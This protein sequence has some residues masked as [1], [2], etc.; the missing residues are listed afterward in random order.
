MPPFPN[1]PTDAQ[2]TLDAII[3]LLVAAV[4]AW[5]NWHKSRRPAPDYERIRAMEKDMGLPPTASPPAPSDSAPP[6]MP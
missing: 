2:Y 6:H 3:A 4:F 1:L 5:R